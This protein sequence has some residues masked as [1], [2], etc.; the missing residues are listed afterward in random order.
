MMDFPR[1]TMRSGRRPS[2]DDPAQRRRHIRCAYYR[3]A[4]GRPA[5]WVASRF[6]VSTR[7][8]HLWV[9]AALSYDEP[10]AR[11]LRQVAA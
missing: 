2:A 8:V 6:K 10:E 9:S 4:L 3:L 7:T 11:A 5:K 1:T